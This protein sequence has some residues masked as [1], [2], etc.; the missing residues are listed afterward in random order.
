MMLVPSDYMSLVKGCLPL[1]K[2]EIKRGGKADSKEEVYW[3]KKVDG[4]E[5]GKELIH[6]GSTHS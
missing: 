3:G 4:K 2:I 6:Q 1:L 5:K